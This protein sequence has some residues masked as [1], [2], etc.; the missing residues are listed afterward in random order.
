MGFPVLILGES[1]SGKSTSL[2]NFEP[3]EIGIFNVAG[4]PLPF[5]KKLP[6]INLADP[7]KVPNGRYGTILGTLKKNNLKAYV[8]DDSQYLMAFD[9]FEKAN[10]KSYDKFTDMAINFQKVLRAASETDNDTIVYFLH[11]TEL[12]DDGKIKA[13]TIGKMLDNQLVIEGLF[14]IVLLADIHE[15]EYI[16][17]TKSDGSNPVKTPLGMFE[18]ETIPNDLKAVD[19]VIRD[20]W[21]LSPLGGENVNK[22][23]E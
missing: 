8:I 14:P 13:K 11:H 5:R 1:G 6:S 18:T 19:T 17:R 10:I 9:S 21:D 15:G 20:Y 3:N 16:F 7:F 23:Q 4:K 2:R 12:R 22:S